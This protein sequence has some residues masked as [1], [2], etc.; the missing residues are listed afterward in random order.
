MAIGGSLRKLIIVSYSTDVIAVFH[1]R[2]HWLQPSIVQGAHK[3]S[4]LF[5]SDVT[6]RCR[7]GTEQAQW[8]L[9]PHEMQSQQEKHQ[10][11]GEN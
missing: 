10:T 7:V 6:G 5:W 2:K 1:H 3:P 8:L 11:V 4:K 9:L